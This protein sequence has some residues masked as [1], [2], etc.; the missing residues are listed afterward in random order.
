MSILLARAAEPGDTHTKYK[1]GR[2]RTEKTRDRANQQQIDRSENKNRTQA[3]GTEIA[4]GTTSADGW[5]A[6]RGKKQTTEMKM[7]VGQ[8]GGPLP[9]EAISNFDEPIIYFVHEQARQR[10]TTVAG[11]VSR[12]GQ[13]RERNFNNR[14]T[15]RTFFATKRSLLWTRTKIRSVFCNK[16]PETRKSGHFNTAKKTR[17]GVPQI[18][19][20]TENPRGNQTK[21]TGRRR[22]EQAAADGDGTMRH[23]GH[24][25]I[26]RQ[27]I[28]VLHSLVGLTEGTAPPGKAIEAVR[29]GRLATP[30]GS[31]STRYTWHGRNESQPLPAL[32]SSVGRTEG[33][34]PQEKSS[35]AARVEAGVEKVTMPVEEPRTATTL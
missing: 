14:R 9:S 4:A 17:K 3:R 20:S 5:A 24:A 1:G 27:P 2:G 34:A 32:H 25:R 21:A 31:G 23:T 13:R 29:R 12:T 28:L 10:A 16:F 19:S 33:A 6:F 35:G 7:R 8:N 18:Y 15:S 30:D 11:G 22:R 26:E